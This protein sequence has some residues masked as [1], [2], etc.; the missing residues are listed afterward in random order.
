MAKMEDNW[1]NTEDIAMD[2]PPG[3]IKRG[4]DGIKQVC[5]RIF[6]GPAKVCESGPGLVF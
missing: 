6:T 5:E 4:W 2:N 1:A 3:G